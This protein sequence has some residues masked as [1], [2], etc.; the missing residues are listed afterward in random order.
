MASGSLWARDGSVPVLPLSAKHATLQTLT[1]G[2]LVS[3]PSVAEV[4]CESRPFHDDPE[5]IGELSDS[6]EFRELLR[7]RFK[8]GG[9][10]NILETRCYKTW[11]KWCS[12]RLR[13]SRLLGLIDSRVLLGASAKGRPSSPALSHVLQGTVPYLLGGGLYPGGLHIYSA[14]N[15]SDGPSRGRAVAPPSKERPLW[16]EDLLFGRFERFDV[17]VAS[18]GVPKLAGRWLRLLLLLGGDIE[19]NPGPS[20]PP[21]PRGALDLESGFAASTKHKMRKVLGAFVAWLESDLRFTFEQAMS[22]SRAAALSLRAFGLHLF[23]QGY[24][25]YLLVYAITAVQDAFPE[26]RSCLAPAWQVDKK[27]Q[28]VEP[29]QCR[30]VISQ[31]IIQAAVALALVWGWRDWAAVTLIGFLCMLH[32]SEIVPL[33]RQDLVLPSDAMSSDCVACVH[34]RNP[35]TQRFARR[36]HS[37]FD[38]PLTLQYLIALYKDLPL[39]ARLFR[40]SMYVYRRQWNAIMARLGVPYTQAERG[41]T[42]GVLRGSGATFLYLETEDISLVAWRGALEQS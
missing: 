34:V 23:S 7:Y 21:V 40:G 27:W 25:R 13:N 33:V 16:L 5:W 22:S 10:I 24:P 8:K 29:G 11:L 9:H 19:P 18:S 38:D 32:P 37:R 42:P 4:S 36:Q 6:L 15:R 2:G 12:T 41:A 39:D 20:V 14:K 17:A 1:L 30:P 3:L 28:A 35:K 26:Y 31:P